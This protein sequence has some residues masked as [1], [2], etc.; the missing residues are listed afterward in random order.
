MC[1]KIKQSLHQS[2]IGFAQVVSLICKCKLEKTNLLLH[3][4][5]FLQDLLWQQYTFPWDP[6]TWCWPGGRLKLD[7]VK[8]SAIWAPLSDACGR[9]VH[10][11][12]PLPRGHCCTSLCWLC[13]RT[14]CKLDFCQHVWYC[15]EPARVVCEFEWIRQLVSHVM[16]RHWIAYKV[17]CIFEIALVCFSVACLTLHP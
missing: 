8:C 3:L 17:K 14:A 9:F 4:Q 5:S 12:L 11:W 16:D 6:V 10:E 7:G 13:Q 1:E 15:F 2:R